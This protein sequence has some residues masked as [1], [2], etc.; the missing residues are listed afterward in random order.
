MDEP[1][2]RQRTDGSF[3]STFEDNVVDITNEEVTTPQEYL[4]H[5]DDEMEITQ[6]VEQLQV[7]PTTINPPL[8]QPPPETI[9][10]NDIAL[11]TTP[12]V[13]DL[14]LHLNMWPAPIPFIPEP[15]V[16]AGFD[17]TQ[18]SLEEIHASHSPLDDIHDK[19]TMRYTEEEVT[20]YL[21][22]PITNEFITLCRRRINEWYYS[23]CYSTITQSLEH[24]TSPTIHTIKR[25]LSEN[26]V[27]WSNPFIRSI[28]HH[29]SC[30]H[31]TI[32]LR[33]LIENGVDMTEIDQ[34]CLLHLSFRDGRLRKSYTI[35][36]TEYLPLVRS[37]VEGF[38][39]NI[40]TLQWNATCNNAYSGFDAL[41][42]KDISILRY[43]LQHTGQLVDFYDNIQRRTPLFD[44]DLF[45]RQTVT[46][47]TTF[48]QFFSILY[49]NEL[50]ATP[51]EAL[52]IT[53]LCEQQPRCRPMNSEEA[54]YQHIYDITPKPLELPFHRQYPQTKRSSVFY[55]F[56]SVIDQFNRNK[57]Y[58]NG[59]CMIISMLQY[60]LVTNTQRVISF[61]PS[62]S[63]EIAYS[64]W[65]MWFFGDSGLHSNEKMMNPYWDPRS[66]VPQI[67]RNSL[68][69]GYLDIVK[70]LHDV[71]NVQQA[72]FIESR[73]EEQINNDILFNQIQSLFIQT[74]LSNVTTLPVL[75]YIIDELHGN[76][77]INPIIDDDAYAKGYYY[78][79]GS[80]RDVLIS[81]C[82]QAD[83][84][85]SSLHN[86]KEARQI[87]TEVIKCIQYLFEHTDF[88]MKREKHYHLIIGELC[89]ARW[90]RVIDA[91]LK[92]GYG[93]DMII[94]SPLY[95]STPCQNINDYRLSCDINNNVMVLNPF[96]LLVYMNDNGCSSS[97][98]VLKG[99]MK[100][101]VD[102][103]NVIVVN[104]DNEIDTLVKVFGNNR[105]DMTKLLSSAEKYYDWFK[106]NDNALEPYGQYRPSSPQWGFGNSDSPAYCPTSPPYADV[107]P[108]YHPGSP[109]YYPISPA[110]VPTSPQ[111]SPTSPAYAPTSPQYVPT[112]PA[113]SPTS[114]A[115]APG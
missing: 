111:Y 95:L 44:E 102:H 89:R 28:I 59:Q 23:R 5:S 106:G 105:D 112:S 33:L 53:L 24:I 34:G 99:L 27:N 46:N 93:Y 32:F 52:F 10:D 68:M 110:F 42:I 104:N 11:P 19:M 47:N 13:M 31:D 26:D 101:L 82:S 87:E 91:I 14:E 30:Q 15:N 86:T 94:E 108:A 67:L 74:L 92:Y 60:Y 61:A 7:H 80:Y 76:Q 1:P 88:Q 109:Q 40:N 77:Y 71:I 98:L 90:Y 18:M 37:L 58:S 25:F 54:W 84:S 36:N 73:S 65:P 9:E 8:L 97:E 29:V 78:G 79:Y 114:P 115:Y 43:L 41:M 16:F 85:L 83:R 100:Y 39:I 56:A 38:D 45:I 3:P 64:P 20:N 96:L 57:S 66:L 21:S 35:R 63:S 81:L 48:P 50:I 75:R 103:H 72:L 22:S 17:G 69:N 4:S 12:V 51:N 113:Y 107:T 49:D 2:K 62:Y 55:F 70:T 6:D